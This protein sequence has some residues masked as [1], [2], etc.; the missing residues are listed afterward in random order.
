MRASLYEDTAPPAPPTGPLTGRDE[1]EFVIVGAGYTGLRA[2]IHAASRGTNTIVL[3]AEDAGFGGSGR[4]HGHCVPILGFIDPAAAE[5]DLGPERG[6]RFTRMLVDSGK[7]VF[8]LIRQYGIDCEA[9]PTGAMQ[10][11]HA[12]A[13][14]PGLYRQMEF[15]RRLGIEGRALDR[16]EAIALT[17]S[18]AFHGGWIHPDG[19]HLNPLA[20]SRGLAVAA[21]REGARI[22]TG[23]P[24]TSI[25]REA[26]GWR[27]TT[28]KGS[29]LARRVAIAT[30]AYTAGL[31]S[32]L[33]SS[34]FVMQAFGL[35]SQPIDP[36]LR[37][38]IMPGNHS[39]GDT[40]P[41]VRYIR[42]DKDNRLVAGGLV[43]HV[44]GRNMEQTRARMTRRFL[45][46]FPEL[47]Q[48]DWGWHWSGKLAINMDRRPH[49]Y[50]PA[51]GLF[52]LIG[53]SGR[54]LPT[55]TALG[56]VLGE[57][58]IGIA[59]DRLPMKISTPRRL[60]TAPILSLAVPS[61]RGVMNRYLSRRG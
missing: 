17:G 29:V 55:A 6:A 35:A 14:L 48:I 43:E 36:A 27:V 57:A 31:L 46:V 24:V 3:E 1:A 9:A 40:R 21:L 26:A 8:N 19:G 61:V 59:A 2:A 41:E 56:E 13:T 10:L 47:G 60:W 54:G 42:F 49:L 22:H 52:A 58:G 33:G 30:N 25:T 5:R 51:E 11:A 28:P 20:F 45:E 12:P 37:A 38:R 16:D 18:D 15:Y 39:L 23:S 53:Y 7:I 50:N 32:P 44:L 34:Y 4:N